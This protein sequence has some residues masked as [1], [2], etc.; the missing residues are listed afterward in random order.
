MFADDDSVTFS[1][2]LYVADRE[3]RIT[4]IITELCGAPCDRVAA[5]WSAKLMQYFNPC[6]VIL[7]LHTCVVIWG[8]RV[9]EV[10][11]PAGRSFQCHSGTLWNIR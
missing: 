11:Y 6:V 3:G 9:G 5:A 8:S 7:F 1:T 2:V 10:N 4:H